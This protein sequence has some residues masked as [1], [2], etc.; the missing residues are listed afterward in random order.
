MAERRQKISGTTLQLDQEIGLAGM[1]AVDAEKNNVRLFDGV[2]MGGYVI[3]NADEIA[4]LYT[5]PNR[6][7][8]TGISLAG[9]AKSANQALENGWYYTD[10]TTT[11]QPEA[12]EATIHTATSN[13]GLGIAQTWTRVSNGNRYKRTRSAA[14]V[15]T[16]WSRVVDPAYLA[17]AGSKIYDSDRLG[18]QLP[19]YYTAIT[20]RLGYT[21]ANKAGDTFTGAVVFSSDVDFAAVP[22]FK[23]NGGRISI[24][25]TNPAVHFDQTDTGSDWFIYANGSILYFLSDIDGN[26][27]WDAAPY[28]L[29]L[30]SALGT[31]YVYGGKI[32]TDGNDGPGSGLNADFL[33]GLHA[34]AFASSGISIV[35]GN[36]LTGGGTLDASRTLT[37]GQGT[38]ISVA[39]TTV[40]V[41]ATV[42]RDG[43]LPSSEQ[44]SGILGSAY[45]GVYTGS[46]V[47]A[48]SFPIGH[49]IA[50][51]RPELARNASATVYL[52]AS[53][54]SYYT[55][56]AGGAALAGTYR[57]RGYMS[58]D[59]SIM[60]R[61]A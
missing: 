45:A 15:W 32:W 58:N 1:L 29:E 6:L 60:Q 9:A 46:A 5:L 52:H 22:T 8:A 11:D 4:L 54:T 16:A 27:V 43:N 49:V 57:A 30:N 12:A 55:T 35:A 37:V 44:L 40:S 25:G 39:A 53:I 2:L 3:P 61:T 10:A 19:E 48:T 47:D 42:W 51:I 38:G 34:S 24:Q 20:T 41:D 31:A 50:A 28:P 23:G 59:R 21:P 7:T 26:G 56:N 36:G 17:T 33:D 14:G 13:N 18:G